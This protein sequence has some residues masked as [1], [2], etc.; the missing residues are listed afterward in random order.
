VANKETPTFFMVDKEFSQ[1]EKSLII[2][3]H[4]DTESKKTQ[5]YH[6]QT[7]RGKFNI[8]RRY[9]NGQMRYH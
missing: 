7:D 4:Q 9:S 5:S 8:S 3:V 1:M 6:G 2:L